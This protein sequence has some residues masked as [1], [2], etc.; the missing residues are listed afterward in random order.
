LHDGL[1]LD[2]HLGNLK[3]F[4]AGENNLTQLPEEIGT[5]ESLEE[6]YLNDNPCLQMLPFELALCRKLS[7]MS[8]D[9]CPLGAMPP[10]VVDG[11]PSGIIMV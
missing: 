8:I 1:V 5:L 3:H 9:G 4:S 11:G 10:Q 6:L 7:L 2:R